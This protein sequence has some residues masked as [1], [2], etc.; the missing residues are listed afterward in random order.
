MSRLSRQCEILNITQ[1]YRPPRPVTGIALLYF[2]NTRHFLVFPMRKSGKLLLSV[3]NGTCRLVLR[4]VNKYKK[5]LDFN[6]RFSNLNITSNIFL[7][8]KELSIRTHNLLRVS[9]SQ[10]KPPYATQFL[11]SLFTTSTYTTCFGLSWRPSSGVITIIFKSSHC[12]QRIRN[13]YSRCKSVTSP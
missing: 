13:I 5:K 12:S 9:Q 3:R 7:K 10:I 1:P 8:Q 2:Y 6:L 11:C 4:A